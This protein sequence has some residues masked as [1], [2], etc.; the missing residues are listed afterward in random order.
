MHLLGD[1]YSIDVAMVPI[2]DNFTMGIDDAA[3][4]VEMLRPRIAIP[5]HY[6]TFDLIKAD[7]REFARKASFGSTEVK[8]LAPGASIQI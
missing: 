2:G 3:R 7:P 5:M 1:M 4:A 8:T 6:N